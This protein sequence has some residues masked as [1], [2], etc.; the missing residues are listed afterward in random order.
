MTSPVGYALPVDEVQLD[1]LLVH[2]G[3]L[4]QFMKLA[5]HVIEPIDFVPGWHL[6]EIC[7]HLEAVSRGECRRLVINIPPG[8]TKSLS[9]SVFWP[10]YD[11]IY[12]PARRWMFASF[13]AT[14]SQRDAGKAK[15]L[16]NSEWFQDRWG[17]R[18]DLTKVKKLGLTPINIMEETKTRKRQNSATVY[19]TSGGGLRF[20]T[21]VAGKSTG[22]HAHIQ[23]VDDPTKPEDIKDGGPKARAALENTEGWWTRTMASRKVDPQDFSRVVIMQRLAV[24]DLADICIKEGYT[25]LCLPMRFELA[26]ACHTSWGG[27][28]RSM[29]G[30]LLWPE[31][32]TEEAVRTTEK[33]MRAVTAA[34]Q[35]QQRPIAA[36]G[37]T[38]KR[39]WFN[40]RWDGLPAGATFIQS[41]DCTFKD[42]LS[43]DFVCGQVWA[44]HGGRF[45]LVDMVR[46]RMGFTTTCQAIKDMR[47]KWPRAR[48]I[49]VEDKA[50][51]PAVV[52]SLKQAV[53]GLVLWDP[54]RDSKEARA[55]AVTPYFEAGN[56]L[57]PVNA[58]WAED[59]IAEMTAFPL[60]ANDDQVDATT[61]ALLRLGGR[62][63]P[64][65]REAMAKV[66]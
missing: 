58:E 24:G 9:V 3:G 38:F 35:L 27:D 59:Y 34:A 12:H 16:V 33:E 25:L 2:R 36:G 23:V 37:N 42:A 61:Q 48:L 28:R 15:E 64:R 49:V 54:G 60:G 57:L 4:Y 30:E 5:W 11:W 20:S 13:D 43:S 1:R 55:N 40:P 6:E 21:T 56:V 17:K 32:Y 14:L 65:L 10:V 7:K 18:A 29:E 63:R 62:V 53:P 39:E 31:R 19:W 52:D 47:A 66:R 8:C 45:Y 46:D 41:W 51:G 22:W 26:N 50:N 44:H